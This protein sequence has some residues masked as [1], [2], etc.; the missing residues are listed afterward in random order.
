[1]STTKLLMLVILSTVTGVASLYMLLYRDA[2]AKRLLEIDRKWG[3]IKKDEE[4]HLYMIR[5]NLIVG[6]FSFLMI[7]LAFGLYFLFQLLQRLLERV[8]H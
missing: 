1:M 2:E 5:R 7:S 8:T 4:S 6:Y 3:R